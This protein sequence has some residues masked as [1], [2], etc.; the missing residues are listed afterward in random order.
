MYGA[1]LRVGV[2]VGLQIVEFG[3]HEG[4]VGVPPGGV[5]V[6]LDEVEAVGLE[7]RRPR[8]A[9]LLPGFG[10]SRLR[11]PPHRVVVE[12]RN[13]EH[14]PAGFLDHDFE[15]VA[16]GAPSRV[17]NRLRGEAL[18]RRGGLVD[19]QRHFD[20]PL[21]AGL[22]I[23]HLDRQYRVGQV[24]FHPHGRRA[25]LR[26]RHHDP[27]HLKDASV[28][29]DEEIGRMGGNDRQLLASSGTGFP[30]IAA[31]MEMFESRRYRAMERVTNLMLLNA[32]WLVASLPIVT[33]F[34]ATAALFATVRDLQRDAD[35]RGAGLF[36]APSP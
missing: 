17:Q 28:P 34:P 26:E 2:P 27:G 3:Q 11:V 30:T 20:C 32:A 1:I 16:V 7:V 22:E 5:E 9:G 15:W 8:L 23:R 29:L 21:V 18:G 6:S 10:I 25:G 33:V 12:M 13:H 4:V 31:T 36:L 14:L 24:A 35:A 19:R